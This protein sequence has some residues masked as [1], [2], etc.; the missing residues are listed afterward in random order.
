LRFLIVGVAGLP[1]VILLEGDSK[2]KAL[3]SLRS[4]AGFCFSF[5]FESKLSTERKQNLDKAAGLPSV[6]LVWG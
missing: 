5:A 4:F 3:Y 6:I 2:E 1:A